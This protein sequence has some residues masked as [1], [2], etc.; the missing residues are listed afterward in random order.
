[1]SKGAAGGGGGIGV[2]AVA[3]AGFGVPFGAE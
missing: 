1:M 2:K 3:D